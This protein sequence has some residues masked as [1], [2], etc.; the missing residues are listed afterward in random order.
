MKSIRIL[1][2][3]LLSM[4]CLSA[5]GVSP[6]PAAVESLG[7]LYEPDKED[8]PDFT[9]P[10][11]ALLTPGTPGS[12][13][14]SE[15]EL[16]GVWISYLE[17]GFQGLDQEAAAARLASMFDQIRSF[18]LNT[19]FFQIRP[20][21]DA[22]YPTELFPYSHLLTGEQGKDP[23]Y[24]LLQLAVTAAHERGLA[25][26]AWINPYRIQ[27]NTGEALV[28][29]AL[30]TDGPYAKWSEAGWVVQTGT[31]QYLNP[32]IAEVREL[33]AQGAAEVVSRYGVDGVQFDDYFYPDDFGDSDQAQYD[34]YAAAGGT[35]SRDDWRREQV[36]ALL[37]AVYAAVKNA[38]STA[39]FGVSPAADIEK[40]Y[41]NKYADVA[42]WGSEPGYVDY[43]MPQDY[44]GFEN[45]KM[46][47]EAVAEEWSRLVTAPQVKFYLGLA[48]YK[49]GEEDVYAGTGKTEWQTHD[50]ILKRQVEFSRQLAN[51]SGFSIYSYS[52]LFGENPSAVRQAERNNLSSLLK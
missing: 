24:D 15:D 45:A 7:S 6:G 27:L 29:E 22:L 47:F 10:Q 43:L 38:S 39:V 52:S 30:D 20:F 50:D 5:C 41:T 14:S 26:H 37:K 35:L 17:L 18:G 11:S 51:C 48:A 13:P 33:I 31:G 46:P 12:T 16:R 4:L 28:P 19:V 44:F 3:A 42:K 34:A 9:Y 49:T 21:A 1:L 23:G 32:G 8:E 2:W 25:L 36:N 40:N